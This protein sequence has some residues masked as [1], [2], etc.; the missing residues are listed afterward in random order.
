M[1]QNQKRILMAVIAVIVVML[2]YPPFQVI[3]S[4]GV[5]FN[6]GYDWLID[7]PKR[8]YI[9]ATVNVSMLLIQWVGVLVVGGLAFFLAKK[10]TQEPQVSSYGIIPSVHEQP[11]LE[12]PQPVTTAEKSTAI[13]STSPSFRDPTQLTQW[14]R[15]FL[16]AS[17]AI[18]AIALFSGVLQYQLLSDFKLGI[19]S[20]GDLATAAAEA[21]DQRQ[22]VVG[23]FQAGVAI[24]TIILFSMWIYRANF[25]A[26]T[27]GAQNMK[28]T[29]G[30]SVGYYFIP[31]L[32]IWRPYQAMKEIWKA[33]KNPTSWEGEERGSILPWW[34]FFF[35]IAS[36]LGNASFRT[37]MSAK[38]IHELITSTGI[39][40][41]S[42]VVSI[43][44][45]IIALILVGQIHEMQMSHVQRSI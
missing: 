9:S 18:D 20:S 25:N 37:T 14:L 13:A 34:W 29:P 15:Y 4:N 39:T 11:N 27:L 38:E 33:S 7:P 41:A 40:I 42:D 5:V 22:K 30:W 36:M 16:Y 44:A 6:M 3:A 12:A 17:I 45:T 23:L 24:T 2:A 28:F 32:N 26:R 21:N 1:N 19:Y 35:L 31:F 10:S 43:P 8:G